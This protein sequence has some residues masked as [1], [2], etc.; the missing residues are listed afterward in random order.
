MIH[1]EDILFMNRDFNLESTIN[2]NN[3]LKKSNS[4]LKITLAVVLLSVIGVLI[5]NSITK[6]LEE[7]TKQRV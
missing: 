5:A 2:E 3:T 6:R 7:E 4:V 1:A